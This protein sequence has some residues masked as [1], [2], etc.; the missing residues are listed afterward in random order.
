MK[1]RWFERNGTFDE[2]TVI[3]ETHDTNSVYHPTK[4]VV[5][6]RKM[7]AFHLQIICE[8]KVMVRCGDTPQK[9]KGILGNLLRY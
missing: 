6:F 8:T 4:K 7:G 9:F 1:Q 5:D 2:R 3:Y